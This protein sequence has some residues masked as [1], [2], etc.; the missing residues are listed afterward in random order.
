MFWKMNKENKYKPPTKSAG[1]AAMSIV[2]SGLGA[3]PFAGTA[4]NEL[5]NA[6]V[7]SPI[8][9]RRVKWMEDVGKALKELEESMG[10][11]LE[12]L[13]KNDIFID[14]ALEASQIAIKTSNQEKHDAL[15]NAILNSALSAPP[16]EDLQMIYLRYVEELTP[17]HLNLL[18][19]LTD[20]EEWGKR[21]GI[22][23]PKSVF[24]DRSYHSLIKYAL[25]NLGKKSELYELM[26]SELRTRGLLRNSPYSK[27]MKKNPDKNILLYST[28]IGVDFLKYIT[29]PLTL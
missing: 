28:D 6:I 27:P 10:I 3:I 17:S 25:P 23:Y 20:T 26:I 15:K 12:S 5:L 16:E 24:I 29:T 9:K 11:V 8:E 7:A 1:D 19:L 22:E 14:V 13:Q 2:R 21:K 18:A 4:A